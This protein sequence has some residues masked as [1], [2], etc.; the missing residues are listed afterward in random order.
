MKLHLCTFAS[1]AGFSLASLTSASSSALN[2]AAVRSEG[3]SSGNQQNVTFGYDKTTQPEK[4]RGKR[5]PTRKRV[6]IFHV[7]AQS[8]L[9]TPGQ[10]QT[11]TAWLMSGSEKYDRIVLESFDLAPQQ[12]SITGADECAGFTPGSTQ[13]RCEWTDLDKDSE[14]LFHISLALGNGVPA[15]RRNLEVPLNLTFFS[16]DP[17]TGQ[18]KASA[19]VQK[20]VSWTIP[21]IQAEPSKFRQPREITVSAQPDAESERSRLRQFFRWTDFHPTGFYLNGDLPLDIIVS[22]VTATGPKPSILVGTP[23]LV[24]PNDPEKA[25]EDYLSPFGPFDNGNHT[26]TRE[27]GGILYIRYAYDPDQ[28]TKPD[29]VVITLVEGDAAQPFPLFREGITTNDEWRSILAQTTIPFAEHNGHTVIITSLAAAAAQYA[30]HDQN[31]VLNIYRDIISA[32]DRISGLSST[33]EDPRDR[34][35][36]LRPIVVQSN[37]KISANSWHYRAAFSWSSTPEMLSQEQLLRSWTM[38][39][40]LGHQRQHVYTWSWDSL[41]EIT[42]DIYSLAA[43]RLPEVPRFYWESGFLEPK[44]VAAYFKLPLEQRDFEREDIEREV[45]LAMFEQ[46]R[47]AF[48]GDGFYHQLHTISRATPLTNITTSA[49]KK[50]FFMTQASNIFG[51]DLT[52]YFTAWGLRPEQRTIDEMNSHPKPTQDYTQVPIEFHKA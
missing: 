19:I 50:H 17:S 40:E 12:L 49:D 52:G 18:L 36:P 39:H 29:P 33:A 48:G 51:R 30:R 22:G 28:Q 42:V 11:L 13:I 4:H 35:S 45:K 41:V 16:L 3:G 6:P 31:K 10:T 24:D 20:A 37:T 1:L 26:I 23:D 47:L 43:R 25:T 14:R 27:T 34:P 46:L 2:S 32:Q 38:W 44:K 21:Y 8:T 9:I 5:R 15:S 7:S